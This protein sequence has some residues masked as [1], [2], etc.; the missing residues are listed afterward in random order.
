[1]NSMNELDWNYI[2]DSPGAIMLNGMIGSGKTATGF[3]LLEEIHKA[4]PDR[5]IFYY[6][7]DSTH[8]NEL[9]P[10]LPDYIQFCDKIHLKE[11]PRNSVILGDEAWFYFSSRVRMNQEEIKSFMDNMAL[12]RQRGQTLILIIQ[13][14][15][16]LE[17]VSFRVGFTLLCKYI[18]VESLMFERAEFQEFL[19]QVNNG[20]NYRLREFPETKVQELLYVHTPYSFSW[21]N[22]YHA[23][24]GYNFGYYKIGL[25]EFWSD[26][27]S[28]F[29]SRFT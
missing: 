16:L 7:V 17:V 1:M 19:V 10:M 29:W 18:P 27:L 6:L 21:R 2:R 20:F 3:K 9:R 13:S 22:L 26:E 15:A 24:P 4:H 14:L 11:L 8:A 5:P 12:V 25:P 28:V 23:E